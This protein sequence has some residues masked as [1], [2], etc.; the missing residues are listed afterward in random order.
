MTPI[1]SAVTELYS[2]AGPDKYLSDHFNVQ[3]SK[4]QS[5][6]QEQEH[7]RKRDEER[8][9]AGSCVCCGA[10]QQYM[11]TLSS[12]NQQNVFLRQENIVTLS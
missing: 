3:P 8:S 12:N 5:W 9:G 4:H 1:F 6:R 11:E 10:F 2:D 7:P